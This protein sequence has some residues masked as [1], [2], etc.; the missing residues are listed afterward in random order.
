M[1]KSLLLSAAIIFSGIISAQWTAQSTGFAAAS[2]GVESIRIVDANTVWA[3]GYDGGST[4]PAIVQEFTKTTDGG[5]TWTT[6]SIALPD[7]LYS[8]NEICPINATTA[9]IGA[10]YDPSGAGPWPGGVWKTTDSGTTWVQ[11]PIAGFSDPAS[12]IDAMHFFNAS[13]GIAFGDPITATDFEI[14][15]TIDGG[16]NWTAVPAASLPNIASGEAGY[17]GGNRAV[18]DSF[19]GVTN[20]GKIYRTKD[21]GATWSKY[22]GPVTDF[23]GTTVGGTLYFSDVLAST[24]G[25]NYGVCIAR[26]GAVAT[27]TYKLHKTTN[28]GLTWDAGVTYTEPYRSLAFIPG[29]TILVGVGVTGTGATAVQSSAYSTDFGLTWTQID[30][31]TQRTEVSFLNGTTGWAGGFTSATGGGIFKYTGPALGTIVFNTTKNQIVASP[32]PTNGMVKLIA[33]VSAITDVAVF[34]L[35]GKQVLAVKYNSLN[36]VNVDMS[37]LQTGAYLLKATNTAGS[38]D[39]IKIVKN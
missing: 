4:T 26:A 33:S 19:W 17:N 39:T 1:K 7:P 31:G 6:G 24:A 3:L 32:N 25:T 2:R 27:A 35:L 16:A 37:S 15:R 21:M 14:Y 34:D 36:E 18:G 12:F 20:K 28:G 29:S 5:A 8:V 13:T 23:G 9:Y 30:T 38:I 22:T 10:V 11:E